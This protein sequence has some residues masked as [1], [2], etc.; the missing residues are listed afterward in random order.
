M[1]E[2]FGAWKSDYP[3]IFDAAEVLRSWQIDSCQYS[4]KGWLLWTWDTQAPEQLPDAWT[5]NQ[6]AD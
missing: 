1:M 4:V 2:E 6:A 5:P 3:T